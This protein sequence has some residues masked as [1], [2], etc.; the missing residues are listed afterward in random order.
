MPATSTSAPATST[1]APAAKLRVL[2][3]TFPIY[4]FARNVVA[5]RENIH[6]G[7][8]ISAAMGCPHDYVLTPQDVQALASADVL[9]VNGLGMEEFLGGPLKKAN[10]ALKVVDSSAGLGDLL[11]MEGHEHAHSPQ[12]ELTPHPTDQAGHEECTSIGWRSIRT[13][14]PAPARPPKW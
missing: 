4:L 12:E 2:C 13:C 3:S 7:L 9:I 6:L 14:S 11:T 1:S 10:P 8:L 5:G